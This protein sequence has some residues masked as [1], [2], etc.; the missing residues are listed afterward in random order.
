[1]KKIRVFQSDSQIIAGFLDD[2]IDH[3]PKMDAPESQ[4]AKLDQLIL[5]IQEENLPG[6]RE[7]F[8]SKA[9]LYHILMDLEEFLKFKQRFV[10][11]LALPQELQRIPLR[12]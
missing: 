8:L 5:Q 7:E 3:L 6:S 2:I 12:S 11:G 9:R 1:M 4:L 10:A